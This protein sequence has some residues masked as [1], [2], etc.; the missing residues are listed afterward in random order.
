LTEVVLSS[1]GQMVI[2]KRVR[3]SLGLK[4]KQRLEMEVLSDGTLLII[5]IPADVVKAMRL[6]SAERLEH[7]LAEER[8]KEDERAEAMAE[9]LKAHESVSGHVGS[10]REI[11]RQSRR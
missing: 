8:A 3:D 5:P 9:E 7:A 11:Q 10:D 2:P 4:P 6:P 1:K